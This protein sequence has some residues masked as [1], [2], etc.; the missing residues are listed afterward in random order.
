MVRHIVLGNQVL[1]VNIDKQFQVRDIYYPHVGQENHLLGHRQRVGVYVDGRLSWIDEASW[2]RKPG[3]KENTL[4]TESRAMNQELGIELFLEENVHCESNILIRKIT[5]V[6]DRDRERE[7][8]VFFNHDFHIYGDGIGDTALYQMDRNVV[9]HYKK[10]RYFLAGILKSDKGED[11]KGDIDDYA[12]GQAEEGGF[13]GTFRDA[14][15]GILSKNPIAQGSVD[16]TISVHLKIP[17]RF[18]KIIYYYMAAGRD[19]KEVYELNDF[20]WDNGPEKLLSHAEGCQRGWVG[21]TKVDF[22][23]IDPRITSL[24]RRSL[25]V[26]KTQTDRDGAILAANDSDNIQFNRDTYS[27]M[28]PR[29]G[30][31][32]SIAMIHAGF[33]EFT[34]P[35]F[36][37]CRDVLWGAGC[38]LHKYNPDR[39]LGSSWHPWIEYGQQSLPIQEDET[40]LVLHALWEYYQ[41]TEDLDFIEELYKPL[42]KKAAVFM[43]D[44]RH[45]NE[46]PRESYDLWEERRGIYT[47]TSSAVYAG[48][49]AAEQMG[50]LF[51]DKKICMMCQSRYKGLKDSIIKELFDEKTGIF[52]RGIRYEGGNLK[53]KI[54]DRIVDSSVYGLFEFGVLSADD[55]R[56]VETMKNVEEKLWVKAGKGGLARYEND[57]YHRKTD[58]APGNPWIICTLWLAKW[59]IGLGDLK[60]SLELI[61]WVSKCSLETGIMP[62]QIHPM[63]GEPLS[64]A[65][66]TWSHAEFVDT[67]ARY[68]K[69][70]RYKDLNP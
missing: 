30:A 67:I 11:I 61:K 58:K 24:F 68:V 56:V 50:H 13:E 6:N 16:S 33:P 57:L 70:M 23:G 52:V 40:A 60:K 19:F 27:Y 15:D 48:L 17:P 65:P 20:L 43:N 29:D 54:I 1:L 66:L 34:K 10:S 46:L 22:T 4:V 37:F 45:S 59:Y 35:F 3:Y 21:T 32:V 18:S 31:I 12:I 28:W 5:V 69:K 41:A 44:Y 7:V 63:T 8:R 14:E 2:E 53:R 39:T 38:L 49:T 25:L 36:L 42:V 55:P 47:F 62:E 51:S 9:I 64:V 26:I